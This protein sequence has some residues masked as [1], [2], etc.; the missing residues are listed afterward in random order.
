MKIIIHALSGLFSL[1]LIS[2]NAFGHVIDDKHLDGA[3]NM[4]SP[5][6]CNVTTTDVKKVI[7]ISIS[8]QSKQTWRFLS[9]HTPFDAWFS[10]FMSIT[11]LSGEK[12]GETVQ[13][14]GALAKRGEPNAEDYETLASGASLS[15][16]L[17]LAQAY[18]LPSANYLIT[19]NPF[20]LHE[21]GNESQGFTLVC[22]SLKLAL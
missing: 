5:I 22:P 8:N 2:S 13:Y 18:E 10:R 15:V 9:W 3:L 20:E 17:D 6:S 21:M 4:T 16:E 19:I 11:V 7:L 12:E 1:L 14:Q